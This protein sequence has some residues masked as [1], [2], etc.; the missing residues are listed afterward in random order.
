MVKNISVRQGQIIPGAAPLY[1]VVP[2]A[3]PL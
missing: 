1:Q 2:S 3:T